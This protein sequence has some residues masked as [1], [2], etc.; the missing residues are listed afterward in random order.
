MNKELKEAPEVNMYD[1]STK[2]GTTVQNTANCYLI[3]A[4][5]TYKIPLVYGNAIQNGTTPTDMFTSSANVKQQKDIKEEYILRKF[6]DHDDK[7]ITNA[8]I[9]KTNN[10]ANK[11]SKGKLV[12]ADIKGIVTDIKIEGDYIT[13]KVN[14]DKIENGNAVIAATKDDGTV[15]WSW[16]LWF[17]TDIVLNNVTCTDAENKVITLMQFPIGLKVKEWIGNINSRSV[18]VRVKQENSNET[19]DVV[20]TQYRSFSKFSASAV[21]YQF[22]RKD[23]LPPVDN[24]AD[25]SFVAKYVDKVE[26]GDCIKNPESFFVGKNSSAGYNWEAGSM[27]MYNLWTKDVASGDVE[28]NLPFK[29]T[30]YDPSPVGYKVASAATFNN[31]KGVESYKDYVTFYQK[32]KPENRINVPYVDFRWHQSPKMVEQTK[33]MARIFWSSTRYGTALGNCLSYEPSNKK[34]P[35]GCAAW[36]RGCGIPVI[37]MKE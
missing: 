15:V 16:H 35:I 6:L 26:I 5:G 2:G 21:F 31:M 27:S 17:A 29:K 13:F 19:A 22:G 4:A 37:P 8:R 30:I 20:F 18:R 28:H 25:G 1:L 12:W 14:K 10:G 23:A 9:T 11:P 24:P 3:K 34:K 33:S 36:R 7:P 32:D